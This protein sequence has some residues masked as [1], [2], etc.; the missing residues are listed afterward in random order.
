MSSK[1]QS[2]ERVVRPELALSNV[3]RDLHLEFRGVF[4]ERTI[5]QIVDSTYADLA[6]HSTVTRWLVLAV[7]KSVRQYLQ[8]VVDGK[9]QHPLGQVA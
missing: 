5:Q 2:K 9:G 8:E 1:M 4:T 6:A 7:E 3:A